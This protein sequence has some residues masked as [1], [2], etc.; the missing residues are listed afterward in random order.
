M[1][2]GEVGKVRELDRG[3]TADVCIG[4]TAKGAAI[5]RVEGSSPEVKKALAGLKKALRDEAHELILDAQ[6][7]QVKR[8]RRAIGVEA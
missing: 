7:L 6:D 4:L 3:V 2:A 8:G 5:V 1:I